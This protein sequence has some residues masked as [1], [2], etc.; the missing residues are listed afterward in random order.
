MVEIGL[1]DIALFL[2]CC[3]P[4]ALLLILTSLWTSDMVMLADLGDK[5]CKS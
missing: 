2:V 3:H 1:K 4:E 5:G